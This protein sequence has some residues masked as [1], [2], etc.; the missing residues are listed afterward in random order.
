MAVREK[1]G[2]TVIDQR[3]QIPNPSCHNGHPKRLR[4][5]NNYSVGF[6]P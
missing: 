6:F 4:F 1:P 3:W 2:A 5:E